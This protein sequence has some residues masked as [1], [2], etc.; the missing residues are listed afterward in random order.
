MNRHCPL[1]SLV[2][3]VIVV[4]G[5]GRHEEPY[6]T[7]PTPVRVRTV[8]LSTTSDGTRYSATITPYEEVDLQFKVGGYIREIL[9]VRGVEGHRRAIQQGDSVTK[10]MVLAR[11]RD[12][13]YVERV[14]H[15]K[16]QLTHA[17]VPVQKA[18][19]DWDRASRLFATQSLTKPDYDS[20]KAQLDS[21]QAGVVGARSQVA[22]A[23]LN[24]QDSALIAPIDG[25]LLQRKIEVGD[26]AT[27]GTIGFM[28]GNLSSVKAIFGVPDSLLTQLRLGASLTITTESLRG[29]EFAGRVTA[30]SPAADARSRVFNIEVT[31]PNPKQALKA[32]MIASLEVGTGKPPRPVTVVPISA[33]VRARTQ[34]DQYAVFVVED[35]N[36]R[37]IARS[38]TAKLGEVLGNTIGVLEGISVGERVITT[39]TTL[40]L[41]GQAVQVIP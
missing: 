41:D 17:E 37:Q 18:Q 11:V 26:L 4:A 27:P 23:Q 12:A 38:R 29:A 21:A 35:N 25:V 16:A 14:K 32:G 24:L 8:G 40:A 13:D 6:V 20:A 28:L 9:Q 39:G 15:A 10:G 7:T 33:V 3:T 19:L 1:V 2:A 34:A 22:E 31:V 30:I 36:G 5:C